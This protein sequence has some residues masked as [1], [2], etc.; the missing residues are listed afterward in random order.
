MVTFK[1]DPGPVGTSEPELTPEA[2]RGKINEVMSNADDLYHQHPSRLGRPERVAEVTKLFEAAYPE[3]AEEPPPGYDHIPAPVGQEYNPEA[4][5]AFRTEA[6]KL[7]VRVWEADHWIGR[8]F[9][10]EPQTAPPTVQAGEA[11]LRQEWRESYAENLALA[12]AFRDRLPEEIRERLLERYGNDPG[13][14]VRCCEYERAL[15]GRQG[16]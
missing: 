14:I 11:V 3:G 7:G 13:T 1:Q 2:A 9:G 4:V 10:P 16:A 15:R 5:E 12:R 6:Q 8:L